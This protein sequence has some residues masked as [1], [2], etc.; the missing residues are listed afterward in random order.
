MARR[1]TIAPALETFLYDLRHAARALL[2]SPSFAVVAIISI[3]LGV[4]ANT[5]IFSVVNAVLLRPIP[6]T[7]S[8]RLVRVY[9]N[10]HSPFDWRD[11]AWF[12]SRATSFDRL[13]GERYTAIGFRS[14]RAADPERVQMSYV[15]RGF[16]PALGVRLA[17]G[18]AFDVDEL[19]ATSSD[20]VAVLSYRFWQRRFAGD[21]SVIGRTILL[22]EHPLTVVGVTADDFRSS[23][24]TWAPDVFVPFSAAP[25]LTGRPLDD[26]GGSFYV[27]GQLASA[28]SSERAASE[29]RGLMTQLARTDSARYDRMSVRLDHIRGVNAELRGVVA[30]GSVFLMGM[31]G[32]VLLIACANVA[33]LLLGRAAARRT[34]IGVRLAIGAS[35]GR[36]VRQML[37]ESFLLAALGSGIGFGG[38]WL[39]TRLVARAV[40]AEA[41]LDAAYFAPDSSVLVFTALVCVATTLFFGLAPA[42]RATSPNLVAALKGD[43]ARG[44]LSKRGALIAVQ[45]AMCV[46]LLAVAAIFLRS[47]SSMRGVDPGFHAE[48]IVDADV[49]LGLLGAGVDRPA[50]FRSILTGASAIPGVESAT[51]TAVV[52]LS[53]SNMETRVLPAGESVANPH[54]APSVYFN[55]VGP[56]YFATLRTPLRRGREF[57]DGDRPGAPRVAVIN[58]TAARRLWPTSDAI[59]Q[60]LHWGAADGPLVEVVGIARDADYVMPGEVP[61]ATVYVPFAQEPRGEMMLQLRTTMSLAAARR[62][63]WALLHDAAPTLP[64]PPVA[65]MADDMAITLLPVRLG[66]ALLGAFGGLALVLAAT[67]I[68]GVASY[69]VARRTREIGIRAALGATRVRILRMVLLESGRSVAAGASIGLASTIAVAFGLSRVLYGV[70]ALDVVVLGTVVLVMTSVAVLATLAPAA[71]AARVDPVLAMRAE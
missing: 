26:F 65:R 11:L 38:A 1:S 31:V 29:L 19:A 66:A 20:N 43:D 7:H 3:A 13:L 46:L 4:A 61:K 30:A 17:A 28:V 42:L 57:V 67:G 2:R 16:F 18:R 52:P 63:V 23:V 64:P 68:Y 44:R 37:T 33:N 56:G 10:D 55:V 8:D 59:G 54:D 40:P 6:G 24:M 14:S 27:T 35:R 69:S 50:G 60:R 9:V 21:S 15:T 58:E 49:D 25:I 34:E 22:A 51:L 45:T 71:R 70:H 12:R 36:L 39:L 48:G 5:T 32:L 62:A 53:G 41:G 47:L